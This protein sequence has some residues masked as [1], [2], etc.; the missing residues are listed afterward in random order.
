MGKD[1]QFNHEEDLFLELHVRNAKTKG[2]SFGE[3]IKYRGV[4]EFHENVSEFENTG[5]QKY[6]AGG[7]VLKLPKE[8]MKNCLVGEKYKYL[9]EIEIEGNTRHLLSGFLI[10]LR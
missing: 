8:E 9:I 10:P 2:R 3:R 5:C 4:V 1:I 6:S 7:V